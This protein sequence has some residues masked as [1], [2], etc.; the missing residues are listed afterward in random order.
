MGT[1]AHYIVNLLY[2]GE[3][4]RSDQLCGKMVPILSFWGR[5]DF[6]LLCAYVLSERAV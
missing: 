4:I 6:T 1:C 2:R 3:L 5:N